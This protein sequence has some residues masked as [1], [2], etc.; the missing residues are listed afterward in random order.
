MK[1]NITEREYFEGEPILATP[2]FD[3]E[4]TLVSARPVVP[5]EEIKAEERSGRRLAMGLTVVFSMLIGALGATLIYRQRGDRQAAVIVNTA[6]PGVAGVSD[7]PSTPA[8]PAVENYEGEPSSPLPLAAAPSEKADRAI[9]T[10]SEG[11]LRHSPGN[12]V[13]RA[14]RQSERESR[15]ETPYRRS[16]PSEEV[17]RIREIFEGSRRP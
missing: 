13:L 5:L 8:A 7:E 4:A 16:K 2:H 11:R 10:R 9:A 1:A 3:E 17:L 6:V 14:K 12:E 15:Q